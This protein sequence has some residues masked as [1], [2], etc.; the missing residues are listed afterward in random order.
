MASMHDGALDAF[1][2]VAHGI[3]RRVVL[4]GI[5]TGLVMAHPLL[6]RAALAQ[7]T[8]ATELIV[9]QK[10]PLV[11]EPPL[12]ALTSPITPNNLFHVLTIMADPLPAIAPAEWRLPVEGL[13]ERSVTLDY[14]QLKALPAR[15]M[16]AVLECA[17]NSRNS[18]SPPLPQSY[19]NNGYVGNAVWKG[20]P[21]RSVLDQAGI[22][23]EAV[24]VV[25]EGAD[26]GTPAFAPGEVAY[27]KSIPIDKA[28]HPDTL[29]VYEMNGAPLPRE[30]GGPVRVLTPGWYGT[31]SVKWVRR[32]EAVDQPFQGVFM[33]KLWRIRERQEGFVRLGSVTQIRVKSLIFTPGDG[34][35]L[36]VGTS[37]IIKGAAWSGGKDIASVQVS[38]DGGASW[39][40]AR[41]LQRSEH[42]TAY[43][44]RQWELPWDAEAGS[45][46][47]MARATDT[48]GEA[49]PFAYD[50]DRNGFAVN[51]VQP[52]QV[53]VT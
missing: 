16:A 3:S 7:A 36:A 31:Y 6:R 49:Q 25:L 5:P 21:L 39:R 32:I 24:E 2:P 8:G 28:L 10:A 29:L 20:A 14:E 38:T 26:R 18:V 15:T 35:A 23:A 17:G 44:W 13:V 51:Q 33:T 11:A 45:H 4:G 1:T 9:H 53:K 42:G 46:T 47:L 37:H 34:D 50:L 43:A 40:F 41:L 30:H 48:S 52:V 12:A 27:A 22:K 19:L